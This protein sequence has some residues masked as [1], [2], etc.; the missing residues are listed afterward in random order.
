M[1]SSS[2][3]PEERRRRRALLRSHHPDRGG[4]PEEF[5]R[6]MA[7]LRAGEAT[8]PPAPG[9]ELRF[10][11]RPRGLARVAAWWDYRRRR[12]RAPRVL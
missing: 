4:N 3:T 2:P 7:A 11:R 6:V 8:T 9:D 5:I 1:S 10:V 12:R